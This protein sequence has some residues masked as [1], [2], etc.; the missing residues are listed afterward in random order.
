VGVKVLAL[1]TGAG[2]IGWVSLVYI[3][4]AMV[5][6]RGMA[7]G[8]C[9][10]VGSRIFA[11]RAGGVEVVECTTP[12]GRGTTGVLAIF[13]EDVVLRL[14]LLLNQ[15]KHFRRRLPLSWLLVLL[16]RA[17]KSGCC[18]EGACCFPRGRR[19]WKREWRCFFSLGSEGDIAG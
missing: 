13:E 15:E 7:Y 2:R 18:V 9:D 8:A 10:I 12:G 19:R 5:L 14:L 3:L 11:G 1:V 17:L 16:E 6:R 4:L